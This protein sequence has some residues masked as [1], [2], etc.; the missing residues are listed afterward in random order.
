MKIAIIGVGGVGGYYGG[1]LAKNGADV[2]F[3]AR[4]SQYQALKQHGLTVKTVEGDFSISPI[5]VVEDIADLTTPEVIFICCKSYDL[6]E[7]AE[8]I[9]LIASPSTIVIPLLNGINNDHKIKEY[10]TSGEVYPGLVYIISARTAPGVIEQTAGPR[11]LFFGDRDSSN[12]TRLKQLES[13]CKNAGIKA[14]YAED[15]NKEIWKK[16]IWLTAFSGMTAICRS[17]IG[18]IAQSSYGIE[19]LI[20]TID[21]GIK[22][23]F[24]EGVCI[25]DAERSEL[26]EKFERYKHQDTGAKS[27]LLVD[28]ENNRKTEIESL[29]GQMTRLAKTHSIDAPCHQMIYTAIALGT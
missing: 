13:I 25:S 7:V 22:I 20:R 2:T 9:S 11:T 4:G 17:A 29:S 28:I 3:V 12:N 8:K 23:A 19:L 27:S 10:V 26:L 5:A 21:E 18:V 6:Q 14:T 16:F 15:I 24:A 1:L